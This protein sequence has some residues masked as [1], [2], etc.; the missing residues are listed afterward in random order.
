MKYDFIRKDLLNYINEKIKPFYKTFDKAHNLSHF[1]FVTTNCVNYGKA[2]KAKGEDVNIEIA[3]VVGAFHDIGISLGREG[4]AKSS[5]KM[6]RVDKE[7]KK[8][9]DDK[10]IEIIAEACEDHSSHLEYTPRSIY[11]KIVGDADR[12]NSL[13]LVFSR[14]IKYGIKNDK[15]LSREEQISSVYDFVSKKFGR[16]GYVKYWLDISETTR[17]QNK[18]WEL[19][20]NKE[21][22]YAYIS[23]IIDEVTKGKLR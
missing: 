3:F 11:G 12:N 19:L 2:L 4:H 6:V 9:F 13:Y 15:H 7:L 16:Q 10:T 23:G 22:C 5:G 18:V 14:P 1:K 21:K 8:F 20:D 17:E